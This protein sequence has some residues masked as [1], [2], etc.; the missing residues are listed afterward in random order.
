MSVFVLAVPAAGAGCG[1]LLQP[2]CPP[3]QSA[4]APDPGGDVNANVPVP[5]G[6]GKLFGFN[7]NLWWQ[8]SGGKDLVPF[9][10]TRSAKAGAQL[11]RTTVTWATL[12][13]GP[14]KPLGPEAVYPRG[15]VP[16]ASA[17][18]Q[19]D[20]L[21]DRATAAG[22]RLDLIV[23]NAPKWASAYAYCRKSFGV[24]PA[25]CG[26]VAQGKRLYPTAA[27]L[28]DLSNFVAAL[29]Q[30]YPGA[31]FETWNEPNLDTGPQAVGGAFAGQMQCAVWQAAKALP[32]PSTV[33][34]AAFGDF[35]GDDATRQYMRDFYSTG[36]GCFDRLSVHTYNEDV[37]SFGANSPL[38]VHM[39]VYRSVRAEE[40][41]T[42]PMW[43]TEFGFST[44]HADGAVSEADQDT[45]TREE[46]NK[47]LS[48][49]DVEAAIVH[50]LRDAPL[51]SRSL[52]PQSDVEYGYGW[53]HQNG[54]PK[55]VYCDFAALAGNAC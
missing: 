17:L 48:M 45:L 3:P 55:P 50:T 36:N 15:A 1:G 38:A 5:P 13:S 26:P 24:Y 19:L 51:P 34:S 54:T 10:V 14:G 46:Y 31:V 20:E 9:E 6:G 29:G 43:V 7:T 35:H 41:D 37:H 49:P 27:H 21:Y 47:L 25:G 33:L 42:R 52:F 2:S 30:R 18:R 12:S 22:L 44:A 8:T 23:N 4:A 28:Q 16:D 40:A 39:Q 32:V 11:I 53:I